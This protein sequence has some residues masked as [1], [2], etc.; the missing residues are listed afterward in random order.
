MSSQAVPAY[1][2]LHRRAPTTGLPVS[3]VRATT[4]PRSADCATKVNTNPVTSARRFPVAD[5]TSKRLAQPR[6]RIMPTPNINPPMTAPDML[7]VV[8]S[9]RL[10]LTS[11]QPAQIAPCTATTPAENANSQIARR[12]PKRPSANSTVAARRQKRECWA[13]APKKTPTS[14]PNATR[15]GPSPRDSIIYSN[16]FDRIR[17]RRRSRLDVDQTYCAA[18]GIRASWHCAQS[19]SS[20]PTK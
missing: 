8:A 11:S 13:V 2:A 10:W 9:W 14:A 1:P 16:M 18:I 3:R 6:A 7:P 12:G 19:V 5:N 17:P 20:A 15:T 4:H